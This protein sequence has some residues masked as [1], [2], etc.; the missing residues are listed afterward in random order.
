[1]NIHFPFFR[2]IRWRNGN[3]ISARRIAES[4]ARVRREKVKRRGHQRQLADI[5][6]GEENGARVRVEIGDVADAAEAGAGAGA[7]TGGVVDTAGAGVEVK[8]GGVA[9]AAERKGSEGAGVTAE[10]NE[11]KAAAA[12]AAAAESAAVLRQENDHGTTVAEKENGTHLPREGQAQ[13][14]CPQELVDPLEHNR[15][16]LA[17]SLWGWG[18]SSLPP[19]HPASWLVW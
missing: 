9:D 14:L 4:V 12:A 3:K 1:V 11:S 8:I 16:L 10:R 7:E 19:C 5:A 18:N 2:A 6:Q 13:S 15:G 17:N